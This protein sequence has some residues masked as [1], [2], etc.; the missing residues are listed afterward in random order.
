MCACACLSGRVERLIEAHTRGCARVC[1]VCV[2]LCVRAVECMC[3]C[4]YICGSVCV[5]VC[6][7][8]CS[9]VRVYVC[10]CV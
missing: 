9:R 1:C 7:R 5:C 8:A 3:V 2:D 4:V 10:V 6:A